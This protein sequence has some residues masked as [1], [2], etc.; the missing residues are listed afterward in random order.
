MAVSETG[1]TGLYGGAVASG[2]LH[3]WTVYE[4]TVVG[5]NIFKLLPGGKYDGTKPL[6]SAYPTDQQLAI[7]NP[8]RWRWVEFQQDSDATVPAY[9]TLR[10]SKHLNTQIDRWR[11]KLSADQRKLEV[12]AIVLAQDKDKKWRVGEVK[13]IKDETVVVIFLY[14]GIWKSPSV[15]K[16]DLKLLTPGSALLLDAHGNPLYPTEATATRPPTPVIDNSRHVAASSVSIDAR[17]STGEAAASSHTLG[18]AEVQSSRSLTADPR[19]GDGLEHAAK[20]Q[21]TAEGHKS[22][23]S[24]NA[25]GAGGSTGAAAASDDGEPLPSKDSPADI[26]VEVSY[27]ATAFQA[28]SP[29][30][31]T[32]EIVAPG[33]VVVLKLDNPMLRE[34]KDDSM[35]PPRHPNSNAQKVVRLK[36]DTSKLPVRNPPKSLPA[37]VVDQR[38]SAEL[39]EE[40]V[41]S[42]LLPETLNIQR[43]ARQAECSFTAM[44]IHYL[45]MIHNGTPARYQSLFPRTNKTIAKKLGGPPKL[46]C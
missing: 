19:L 44:G 17:T 29:S 45:S 35:V 28:S 6:P 4:I 34:S 9:A 41:N 3:T 16:A 38:S 32:A 10:L 5:G 26:T 1:A 30:D 14:K 27:S 13:S 20:R 37:R 23:L 33:R 21:K 18:Q 8:R 7:A 31:Q 40:D 25:G 12:G 11:N 43:H 24:D 15:L 39:E 2:A 22:G 36:V 46:N 42:G